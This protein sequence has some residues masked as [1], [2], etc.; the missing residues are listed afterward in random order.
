MQG[1]KEGSGPGRRGWG[2]AEIARTRP[3]SAGRQASSSVAGEDQGGQSV[4]QEVKSH[5]ATGGHG[6]VGRQMKPQ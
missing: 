4:S 3:V 5:Q 1:G 2:R 6:G